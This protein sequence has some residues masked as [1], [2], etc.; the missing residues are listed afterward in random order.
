MQGVTEIVMKDFLLITQSVQQKTF[1]EEGNRTESWKKLREQWIEHYKT[2]IPHSLIQ[3]RDQLLMA[4]RF[5]EC[6]QVICWNEWLAI[7]GGYYIA[8]RELR[9]ILEAVVQAYYI[10]LKYPHIDV[11]GK[12][13]VLNEM[14][15]I[16]RRETYGKSL[17]QRANP[18]NSDKIKSLYTELCG[19]V[20]PSIDQLDKILGAQDRDFRIVE[21]MSP[22]YDPCLFDKCLSLSKATVS[23]IIDINRSFVKIIQQKE[24][25]RET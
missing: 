8:I 11:K 10:D 7:S 24:K 22:Q 1:D 15:D 17:I 21:L 20:H 18:P 12:L 14:M 3:K 23:H 9:S 16:G 19:F 25:I 2:E 6:F 13:A 4:V 5:T